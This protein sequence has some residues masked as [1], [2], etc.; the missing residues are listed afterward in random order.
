MIETDGRKSG[1]ALPVAVFA[2]VV[3]GVMVTG[4]FYVARQESRIGVASQKGTQAFY[5][6]ERGVSEVLETWNSSQMGALEVQESLMRTRTTDEGFY[7][8]RVTKLSDWMYFLESQGTI[9][10]GG[11]MVYGA[12]RRV[13]T[14]AKIRTIDIR[15]PAALTTVGN[16]TIAG[17]AK[18]YGNDYI[19][20]AWGGYCDPTRTADAPGLLIDDAN[21]VTFEG[22][23]LTVEGEPPVAEDPTLTSDALL[24]FGDLAWEDLVSMATVT[25]PGG[26]LVTNT[27]PDSVL[28]GGQW[29]CNTANPN[30]WGDP[31]NPTG[32]C[33][34]HFPVIYAAGDFAIQSSAEGQGILLVEG[35]LEFSGGYEF[36]GPVIVRGTVSTS[37]TGGH[38][39]GGL[40]AANINL[41]DAS[42]TGD[43][44]VQYSTCTVTRA[45]L[46]NAALAIARPLEQRSWVDMSNVMN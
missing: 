43:A 12:T 22:K 25:Y 20:G 42:V 39:I 3:V 15:P 33:G 14:L 19:P 17:K 18:V 9:T 23:V 29:V 24:D 8:V 46:N 4:G 1:F 38:F 2:L 6:A 30:N 16:A 35:N 45:L 27:E 41:E 40:I 21:S 7:R 10:Q 11:P 32:A 31:Y 5:L 28:V 34:N 26:T 44:L 37:G 36:F 13:G